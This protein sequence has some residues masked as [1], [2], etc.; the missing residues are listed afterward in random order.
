MNA[1][2]SAL[3]LVPFLVAGVHFMSAAALAQ[4]AGDSWRDRAQSV[5]TAAVDEGR[6]R[7]LFI[8]WIS[9]EGSGWVSAGQSGNP[10]RPQ[11]DQHTRFEIGSITKVFTTSLLATAVER[12]EV[13]LDDPLRTLLPQQKFGNEALAT[14]SL[15]DLA[16]HT[17]GLA[18]LP[19]TREGLKRFL[20]RFENPYRGTPVSD[21]WQLLAEPKT[22]ESSGPL[23]RPQAYSNFGMAVLGQTLA[24][25]L[26]KPYET[27]IEERL[28][29][30]LGMQETTVH[31]PTQQ[32]DYMAQGHRENFRAT[33]RWDLDAYAPA[34]GIWSSGRDLSRFLAAQ[35]DQGA[36]GAKL[37]QMPHLAA[38]GGGFA[39][40]LGWIIRDHEGRR[41]L[42]HNGGTGGFRS[43]LA[44]E[45]AT[46]TGILVLANTAQE[47]DDLGWQLLL[48]TPPKPVHPSIAAQLM[49][50][51]FAWIAPLLLWRVRRELQTPAAPPKPGEHKKGWHFLKGLF[52]SAPPQ[53][54]LATLTVV[55]EAAFILSISRVFGAWQVW[56]M[57]IWWLALALSLPL[58]LALGYEAKKLPWVNP[59]RFWQWVLCFAGC[60]VMALGVVAVWLFA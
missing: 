24:Q 48:G 44:F 55:A 8:A 13:S 21:F 42:W 32:A 9:P 40:G 22:L 12:G 3:R 29:H 58:G 51:P 37:A 26:G 23:P 45:A 39:M 27:L 20:L 54:R 25:R 16:T 10:Q 50:W 46:G 47:V 6:S 15:R 7:G 31:A 11:I 34:G 1:N 30:P 56:P 57:A 43:F 49:S 19:L 35:I 2:L 5:G 59:R 17:S 18:R 33:S 4:G 36:P 14:L 52:Q 28:L 41:A 53:D 60:G 38:A